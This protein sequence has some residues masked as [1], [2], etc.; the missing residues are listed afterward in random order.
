MLRDLQILE[1]SEHLGSPGEAGIMESIIG[2]AFAK[3]HDNREQQAR[4]QG[5]ALDTRGEL[6]SCSGEMEEPVGPGHAA[7]WH[8]HHKHI[9]VLTKNHT[10][11]LLEM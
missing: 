6:D 7:S 5:L 9:S 3:L 11:P 10:C 2:A 4:P 8:L 1:S